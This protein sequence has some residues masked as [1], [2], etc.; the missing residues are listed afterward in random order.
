MHYSKLLSSTTISIGV[1]LLLHFKGE[2]VHHQGVEIRIYFAYTE[3]L[4]GHLN[5]F[6]TWLD[7]IPIHYILFNTRNWF[8]NCTESKI[9]GIQGDD[10]TKS[11]L[12]W[13]E[14]PPLNVVNS[15]PICVPW[16]WRYLAKGENFNWNQNSHSHALQ[17]DKRR[18]ELNRTEQ[19][20]QIQNGRRVPVNGYIATGASVWKY[21]GYTA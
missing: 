21:S 20:V 4:F 8:P 9:R 1:L 17:W 5:W 12:K 14:L 2:D 3:C 7:F 19:L 16:R 10:L 13:V 11:S 18:A 6:C 15:R